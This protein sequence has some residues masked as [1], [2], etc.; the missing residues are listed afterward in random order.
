[1]KDKEFE[2]MNLNEL[3]ESDLSLEDIDE[4]IEEQLENERKK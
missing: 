3:L 2:D 4:V 1:M